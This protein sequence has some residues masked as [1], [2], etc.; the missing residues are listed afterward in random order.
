MLKL[1]YFGH[2]MRR[3]NSSEKTL[4]LGKTEGRR[5]RGW[6]RMRWLDGITDSMDM[7][8]SKLQNL[9][10]DRKTWHCSPWGCRV[11][12]TEL[13]NWTELKALEGKDFKV[14]FFF[15]PNVFI[16]NEG[17]MR[18]VLAPRIVR[19]WLSDVGQKGT[20]TLRT[21]KE[22]SSGSQKES[23]SAQWCSL[24]S[25]EISK[26]ILSVFRSSGLPRWC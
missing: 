23:K 9:V 13:S 12:A 7:S 25:W 3:T 5:R 19:D 14:S 11:W 18:W 21:R 1:Q 6:W 15:S 10:M 22:A 20:K 4:I 8:L 2:L 24:W 26:I 16:L 17:R